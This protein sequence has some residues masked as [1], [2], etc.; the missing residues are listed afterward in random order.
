[1]CV[2]TSADGSEAGHQIPGLSSGFSL[3]P[4]YLG[5][6]TRHFAH[7]GS[8]LCVT[9]ACH[10]SDVPRPGWVARSFVGA[11][12]LTRLRRDLPERIG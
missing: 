11:D 7:S 10:S 2:K 1:M 5:P 6:T 12:A 9:M 3:D 8:T 4:G